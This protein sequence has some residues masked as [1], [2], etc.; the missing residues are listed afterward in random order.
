MNNKTVKIGVMLICLSTIASATR[1]LWVSD[2]VEQSPPNLTREAGFIDRLTAEGYTVDRLAGPRTM[3]TTKR[4]LAN[5]Y[6]LVII[7][8]P[9]RQQRH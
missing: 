6:D 2:A 5:T 1:I 8:R 7:S 9:V 3:D 4:D